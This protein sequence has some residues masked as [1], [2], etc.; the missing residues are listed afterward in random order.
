MS[1][2]RELVREKVLFR[3]LKNKSPT[4]N[5]ICEKLNH[6]VKN[7]VLLSE[8]EL[9]ELWQHVKIILFEAK[10]L[11]ARSS[12][13]DRYVKEYN[14]MV[15][16]IREIT[17]MTLETITQRMFIPNVL[18]QNVMLLHSVIFPKMKNDQ[19]KDEISCLLENWW[20]LDMIWKEK[21]ITNSLIYLIQNCKSSL[22][23]IKR[24]YEI[25]SSIILLKSVEHVQE[26]LKLVREK[27]IMS[28][29]EGRMLMLYLFTLGEEYILGIH[30][31]T[32]V[33]LQNI[34]HNYINGYADL[35][36]T[37]WSD[38]TKKVKKFIIENCLRD[39]V[40]H[41]F[42]AY[43]DSAGRGKLGKN[44]LLFLTAI[45]HSKNHTTRFMIH[46]Q[47]KLLLWK[48]LKGPGSY[49]KCNAIEI[50]FITSSVHFT[51]T[52]KSRNKCYLQKYYKTITDLLND[53]DYEVCNIT[54]NGLFEML[55]K[56]WNS[57]PSNYINDWLSI[58]L[59]Y[60]KNS[61]NSEMRANV[62]IGLKNIL[63]KK[64]S[65]KIIEDFLPNFA[66][67]IYDEDSAVL[68]ALIKFLW[69]AQNQLEIPFWKI[70]PLTYI[71]DRMETTR[72]IV[73]LRDLIKL[74]WSRISLNNADYD[75]ITDEITDIG[76][77][78][79]NAIRRFCFHSES[80]LSHSLSAKLIET[81]L[82]IIEKEIQCS[83]SKKI[84]QKNSCKKLKL[85]NKESNCKNVT[86]INNYEEDFDYKKMQIY[87]DVISILLLTNIKNIEREGKTEVLQ[88]I[89]NILPELLKYFKET[90]VNESVIFLFS[91]IPPK[92]FPNF[93]E[94]VDMLVQELCDPKTRD[95][96]ILTII[97]VLMKWEREDTILLTLTNVFTK[98][99]NINPQHN[100]S[101]VDGDG[102]KI[103]EEG[104]ELSL[105]ILKHLLHIEHQSISVNKYH[106]N[107]LEF[108]TSL[109][110]LKIFIE[111]QLKNNCNV[112]SLE[113]KDLIVE[114]FKEYIS[115]TFLLHKED[116]FDA[117]QHFSEMLLWIKKIVIPHISHIDVDTLDSHSTCINLIRTTFDMSNLLL[118]GCNNTPKLCCD[119][120]L[121]YCC[122]LSSES[123]VAFL[124]NAFDAI[125]ILLDFGK[126]A[127]ENQE[128][129]LINIVVPNFVCVT[130]ITLTKYNKGVLIKYTNNL[131]VLRELT[132]K[133]FSII[134]SIFNNQNMCL[135][136]ITIMLNVAISSISTEMTRVLQDATTI[137]ES[138]ITVTF[139]YL[140]KKILNIILNVKK[141]QKLTIQVLTG[142]ITNYTKIDMLSALVVIHRLH[143][144]SNKKIIN[145]LKNLTLASKMHN[146]K[147]SYHTALDRSIRDAM[148]IVIRA[149]LKQ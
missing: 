84:S 125:M 23:H 124:N 139:P 13:S 129:N 46:N 52:V 103:N 94:I 34:G 4:L 29:E 110:R 32:K 44:L 60:T 109:H 56:Y 2:Q 120:V 39:I 77:K 14:Q 20:K 70:I 96:I 65:H 106:K 146:Q 138:I 140:A 116:V 141:Y 135:P 118:K 122:C 1:H 117:P 137:E 79:F 73:L 149:I 19:V 74:I 12:K 78:N 51:S 115:L 58:L 53:S 18:L 35:Y 102:V 57:V 80:V 63:V 100:E 40:F 45:H 95:D 22:L 119:I 9:C 59:H 92:L 85:V 75:N 50:L 49:I 24:L 101:T 87:I 88:L 38:G 130:M 54:M 55:E 66:Y 48:H 112:K 128:P 136:F 11:Y 28:L 76:M 16:L 90:T 27:T 89:A 30:N 131:I 82:P 21:V 71:L 10:N 41:C 148:N 8:D 104:L 31:N 26:L 3:I 97:Y 5:N 147:H 36:M 37:A 81:I 132:Q 93:I 33:V 68:D 43:R 6:N 86:N 61:S 107:I 133:Y 72:N 67:S 62:F 47:C 123:G 126:T 105:R 98:S 91:V 121:L 144:S 127:Y 17:A 134:K 99:L 7:I 114:F 142:A 69:H 42:R 25:K 64:R 83:T 143:K 108:W 113:S 145:K 111:R 15:N